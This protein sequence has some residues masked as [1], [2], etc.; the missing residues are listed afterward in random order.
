MDHRGSAHI[1]ARAPAWVPRTAVRY[2]A[3]TEAGLPIRALAR[4]GACHPSTVMRQIRKWESK[5]DDPLIDAALR[6]LSAT[7]PRPAPMPDH[8][9][10]GQIVPGLRDALRHLLP[11]GAVLAVAPDMDRAV[12]VQP[13]GPG[14]TRKA[15]VVEK[16]VAQV[17]ALRDLIEPLADSGRIVRYILTAQGRAEVKRLTALLENRAQGLAEEGALFDG[18]EASNVVPLRDLQ[19]SETPL[20]GLYR[21]RDKSGRRFLTRTLLKAGERLRE[22]FRLAGL[23]GLD[24]HA[25][26]GAI[27][28]TRAVTERHSTRAALARLRDVLGDLGEELAE[29]ALRCCCYLEGMEALEAHMGWSARSAKIVVRIVLQR[30]DR[31]YRH[32]TESQ[33]IG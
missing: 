18:A 25:A 6:N 20:L 33:L 21:R 22:D 3:H 12:V 5:R 16:T 29:V 9:S 8:L 17:L 27:H 31:F 10:D 30:L 1:T 15:A 32:S 4:E 11:S 28:A 23:E 24:L 14:A 2:I 13:D 7:L 19:A 26:Q